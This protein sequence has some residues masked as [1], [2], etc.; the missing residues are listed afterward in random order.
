[1]SLDQALPVQVEATAP[2]KICEI[3][4]IPLEEDVIPISYGYIELPTAGEI[5]TRQKLFPHAWS[6]YNGGCVIEEAKQ[7]RV[8]FCPECRK[9]E[10]IWQEGQ[11]ARSRSN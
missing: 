2:S 4:N 11:E 7:A 6:S 3:H 10:A 8:S 1:V 5:E 9:A